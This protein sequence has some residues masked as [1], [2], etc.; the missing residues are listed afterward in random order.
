M[1]MLDAVEANRIP[2]TD[3]TAFTARQLQNLGH[4]PLAARVQNLWGELRATPADKARQIAG[5]KRRLTPEAMKQAD[6]S[7]GRALFQK[8]CANCHKL[9]DAGGAIGPE[10][11]GA[12]R[13]NLDYLLENLIDPSAAVSRDFQMQVIQTTGGR[14]I[15]GLAV[16]ENENAVTIQ[17]VNEKVVVPLSEIDERA[18]S[19]VSLMP[20]RMLDKLGFEEVRDLISYLSSP[21][22]VPL[23]ESAAPSQE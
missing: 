15:T 6:R 1:A 4:A 21:G 16:A 9:F 5:F 18:T 14:V 19:R 12:Q 22:Q 10:I 23:P 13:M 3:L 7:A 17:T 20:D 2:R 8:N 11:T